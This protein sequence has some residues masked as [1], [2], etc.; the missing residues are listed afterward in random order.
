MKIQKI[1][2]LLTALL[3][4]PFVGFT[5]PNF[6]QV[7]EY[8]GV[9]CF[10][11]AEKTDVAYYA[12]G[13][14]SMALDRDEK[15]DFNFLQTRYTGNV[16]YSDRGKNR[17]L[18]ILRFKVKME[19]LPAEKLSRVKKALW[20]TGKGHLRPVPITNI[21]AI[22]VFTPVTN[23]EENMEPTVLTDGNLSAEGAEG[24]NEKGVYWKEREFSLR[25]DEHSTQLLSEA[26]ERGNSLMSL[27]YAFFSKG[28]N[29]LNNNFITEGE[30]E[31]LDAIKEQIE[32]QQ[33]TTLQQVCI[34]SDAF[35]ITID[36]HKW[37]DLVRQI[38]INEEVPPG[39]AAMEVRCYDFNNNLRPDLF[40]K[41]IEIKAKGVGRGEVIIKKTFS[42]KSPDIYVYSIKFL[43]AVRL[44]KPLYYRVTSISDDSAPVKTEWIEQYLWTGMIDITST[45]DQII[46]NE[47]E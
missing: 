30:S 7:V 1:Y 11:D 45:E 35:S 13:A 33:D 9:R 37:P 20:P 3:F 10:R 31:I 46:D 2:L 25:V 21:K 41:K 6:K 18:S 29:Q 43:Y 23:Q 44:D 39:Y 15:P 28:V 34:K 47:E 32:Q 4:L 12:P 17:F 19:Q 24:L 36:S 42:S 27:S 40:A 14:L 16:A 22:L 26:F 8:E 5:Q 38:D